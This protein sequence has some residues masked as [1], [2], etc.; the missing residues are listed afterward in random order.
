MPATDLP[1]L[2]HAAC[3]AWSEETRTPEELDRAVSRLIYRDHT[4]T[5]VSL[6]R[7]LAR[8]DKV[9]FNEFMFIRD[10][11]IYGLEYHDF[12]TCLYE[13]SK[14]KFMD[15]DPAV[16]MQAV[17]RA[18]EIA[19][20]L[21]FYAVDIGTDITDE[22]RLSARGVSLSQRTVL[23]LKKL[24]YGQEV[25][26]VPSAKLLASEWDYWLA[27]YCRAWKRTSREAG[28]FRIV[29]FFGHISSILRSY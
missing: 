17:A 7:E 5:L 9:I 28:L 23:A 26:N 22:L 18:D 24:E 6:L 20:E 29:E 16:L 15:A 3:E 1:G 21:A 11:L 19:D 27:D 10:Y 8:Q 2:A 25:E 12:G 14:K 13:N 4:E